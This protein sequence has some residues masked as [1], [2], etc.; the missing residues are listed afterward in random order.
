MLCWCRLSLNVGRGVGQEE[1]R[2][3]T[4]KPRPTQWWE[5]AWDVSDQPQ[6]DSGTDLGK[7]EERHN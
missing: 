5:V 1:H 6:G 4:P 7:E 2:R 3:S